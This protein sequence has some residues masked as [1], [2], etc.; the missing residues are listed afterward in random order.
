MEELLLK[1]E[2]EVQNVL[3]ELSDI[4]LFNQEKVLNAFKK[5]K[6][7]LNH[8]SCSNGYGY[9]DLGKNKLSEVFKYIFNTEESICSPYITCGTH[10]LNAGLFGCLKTG[11]SILSISGDVYDSL[12]N[13]VTGDG[14]GSLKDYGIG[15]EKIEL[16]KNGKFDFDTIG[17]YLTNSKPTMIYLQRSCGY[18]NRDTFSIAELE[19]AITFVKKFVP[20]AIIFVDNCYGTFSE[21]LEPTEVGA[22]MVVGSLMKN[23]GGGIAPSGG[24]I[25]GRKD[26]VDRTAG[27]LFGVGLGMEVG[28]YATSYQNYFQGVFIAPSVVKNALMGSTLLGQVL[29]NLSIESFPTAGKKPNDL[30]RRIVFN[31]EQK[32]VNFIQTVQANS[33]VDSFV[34]PFPSEMP[35]YED[36]VIMAAGGFVQGSSIEMSADGPVR[37][38]YTAYFQGGLTYEHIKIFCNEIIKIMQK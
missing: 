3:N 8:F 19:E 16:L 32:M 20:N 38:P 33:P 25:V 36:K 23:A 26:L 13:A 30:I 10:A 4:A 27:R 34:L 35:G 28:S 24:Y 6:I 17:K 29:K 14:N 1:S 2:N 22:D 31:D 12:K 37:P 21:K 11:D 18:S 7:A 15:F 5:A 9:D